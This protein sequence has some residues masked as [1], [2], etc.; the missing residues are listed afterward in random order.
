MFIPETTIAESFDRA[1][2]L[3]QDDLDYLDELDREEL[4]GRWDRHASPSGHPHKL[5]L[6]SPAFAQT[7]ST[8]SVGVG[9]FIGLVAVGI[10]LSAIFGL[11]PWR[12]RRPPGQVVIKDYRGDQFRATTRFEDDAT[13]MAAQGYF[14]VSQRRRDNGA[15]AHSS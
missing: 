11:N 7:S 5:M 1:E 9:I 14:P 4:E 12:R 8:D 10:I 3:D 15:R 13:K 6:I 2:P